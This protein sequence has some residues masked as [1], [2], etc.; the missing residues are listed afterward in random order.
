MESESIDTT[1]ESTCGAFDSG[2]GAAWTF[3]GGEYVTSLDGSRND[4][5][6]EIMVFSTRAA[7]T[8]STAA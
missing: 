5:I 1:R 7:T 4:D 6:D 8:T 2:F 3:G